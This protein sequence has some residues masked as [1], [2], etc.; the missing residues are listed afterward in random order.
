[1]R[2][3]NDLTIP[4]LQDM[5]PT[6]MELFEDLKE[7]YDFAL[8]QEWL[9]NFAKWCE[10]NFVDVTYSLIRGT[11]VVGYDSKAGAFGEFITRCTEVFDAYEMWLDDNHL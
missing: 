3:F 11:T 5:N 10:V 9:N 2:R 7:C 4:E 8:P 6:K 1:M